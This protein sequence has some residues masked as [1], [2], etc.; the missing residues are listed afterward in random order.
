[1]IHVYACCKHLICVLAMLSGVTLASAFEPGLNTPEVMQKIVTAAMTPLAVSVPA[2]KGTLLFSD[3]PEYAEQSGILYGDEVSGSVRVYFYHVNESSGVKKIVVVGENRGDHDVRAVVTKYQYS[4][5]SAS[6]YHVGKDLST[7]YYEGTS[8]VRAVMV[9]AHGAAILG[10]RLDNVRIWSGQLFSGIVDLELE[11]PL[12]ISTVML[13]AD[14]DT[15]S[16]LKRAVVL[17]SDAAKLRGTFTGKDRALHL[18]AP[19]RPKEGI[20]YIKIGDGAEDAFLQGTDVLDRRRSEDTGNY[21]VDYTIQA[22]TKGSGLIHLYFNTQGGEYSGVVEVRRRDKAGRELTKIVEL[23]RQGDSMGYDNAYAMEYVDSFPAGTETTL[24]IM[25]PGAANLPVRFIFVPDGTVRQIIKDVKEEE[26]Q[27]Q[28]QET[29]QP[30][31]TSEDKKNA[32]ASGWQTINLR[33]RLG[34]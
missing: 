22:A 25:P 9:P 30:P 6:Y 17:P 2:D 3:S 21:G 10:D 4:K 18:L 34:L 32:A 11:S 1:M 29:T 8:G 16:Y 13:P 5:P 24:H 14:A 19:Y 27:G 23:P 28:G 26:A 31:K 20:G 33:E 7:A 12:V 15:L